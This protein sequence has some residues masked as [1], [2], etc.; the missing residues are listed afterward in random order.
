MRTVSLCNP[1]ITLW[2]VVVLLLIMALGACNSPPGVGTQTSTCRENDREKVT[3]TTTPQPQ[4]PFTVE[5]TGEEFQWHI[6]YPGPDGQLGTSDDI[7]ALRN[8]HLPV[9]TKTKINLTSR[10]YIYTLVFP[11]R[12]LREIAVPD[13]VFS[14]E[15]ESETTGTFDLIGDQFC[16]Y[17]HPDLLGKLV[18]QT[19]R[20]FDVWLRQMQRKTR[21]VQ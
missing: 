10:D 4:G 1:Q 9:K 14:L 18:V 11:N 6:R 20:D 19:H 13:M 3:A 7:H 5:I 16:G 15:F 2:L 12:E 21:H 17:A 8:M